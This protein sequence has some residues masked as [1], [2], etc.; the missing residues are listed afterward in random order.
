MNIQGFKPI[1]KGIPPF[2]KYDA[3]HGYYGVL[4]EEEKS[5]K[6]QCHLCGRL[7]LNIA[8]HLYHKHKNISSR[9]YKI[10]TG[11]SLT[12]P[13]MSEQTRKKIKNNF[14]NLTEKKRKEVVK[15]LRNLNKKLHSSPQKRQRENK[16][17]I[18]TNNRYGTCPEQV[19]S[20]F[21]EIYKTLNRVPKWPELTGKLRYIVETRFG[22]YEE[23]CIVWGIPR[24]E[25]KLHI[26]QGRRNAVEAR[27]RQ[28]YFPSYTVDEVKKQYRDFFKLKNRLPTWGEV[29]LNKMASRDVFERVFGC[30]KS[31]FEE[32]LLNK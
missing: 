27:A 2:M 32:E 12:T 16:A 24:Q 5:G 20:Q 17:S 14:L 6:L 4:L 7:I 21:L 15:R 13:L 9:E 3:G 8:K 18:Q 26:S 30:C 23:A 31:N 1:Y 29:R 19:R 11:L 28:N 25:Y 22:S 10:E